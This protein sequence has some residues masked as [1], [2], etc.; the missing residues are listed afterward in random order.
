[1]LKAKWL[2]GMPVLIESHKGKDKNHIL[3]NAFDD[4]FIIVSFVDVT[5]PS[6]SEM[7]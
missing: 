5:F 6:K 1:M 4:H 3:Q 2:P 7:S